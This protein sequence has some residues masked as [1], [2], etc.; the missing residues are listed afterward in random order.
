MRF[1]RNK[2]KPGIAGLF[3]GNARSAPLAGGPWWLRI[4]SID[5]SHAGASPFPRCRKRIIAGDVLPEPKLG[6]RPRVGRSA[7]FTVISAAQ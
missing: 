5:C 1:K 6:R 7:D 2:K 3:F 4:T